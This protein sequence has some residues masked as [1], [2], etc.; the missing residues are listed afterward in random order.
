MKYSK[1]LDFFLDKACTIITKSINW[2]YKAENMMDY[3]VGIIYRI[4]D[5]YIWTK[6]SSLGTINCI[7]L[8]AVISISEEQ[9]LFENNPSHKEIIDEYRKQKPEFAE[10]TIVKEELFKP[11]F[12]NVKDLS[13][14]S[15]KDKS[16]S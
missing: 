14:L 9:M 15:K 1:D 5:K 16:I 12:L 8:E 4:D 6:H 3:F 11:G 10:K 7:D 13:S 2:N